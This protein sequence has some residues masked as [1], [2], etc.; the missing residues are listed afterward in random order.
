MK[1]L[2]KTFN[3]DVG[4]SDHSLGTQVPIIAASCGATVI[5]KHFTISK[6]DRTRPFISLSPSEL[7]SMIKI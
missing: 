2:K 1:S 5:E 6:N 4:Y 7:I 3:L